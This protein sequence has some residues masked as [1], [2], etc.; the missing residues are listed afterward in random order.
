MGAVLQNVGPLKQKATG[1]CPE[2]EL[3]TSWFLQS[4]LSGKVNRECVQIKL[5]ASLSKL[6]NTLLSADKVCGS[7][8]AVL[9]A[10]QLPFNR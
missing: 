8:R 5:Q 10:G 9:L 6:C 3:A 1:I 4:V 7:L 2:L